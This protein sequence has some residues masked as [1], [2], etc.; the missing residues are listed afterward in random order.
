M[1]VD[2][3][4]RLGHYEIVAALGRGAID[5]GAAFFR[6]C[7]AG[8]RSGSSH[9]DGMGTGNV[10]TLKRGFHEQAI[11][12]GYLGDELIAAPIAAIGVSAA[13]PEGIRPILAGANACETCR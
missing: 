11:L 9:A 13:S 4:A 10:E 1:T 2:K 8:F 7:G 12:C 5:D 6:A 3:G